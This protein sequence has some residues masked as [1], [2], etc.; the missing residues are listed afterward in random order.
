M[1]IDHATGPILIVIPTYHHHHHQDTQNNLN[2]S[3]NLNCT[4]H[5]ARSDPASG[6]GA[7]DEIQKAGNKQ[8]SEKRATIIGQFE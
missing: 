5:K 6:E 7:K 8:I 4:A 2:T 1:L 3:Q